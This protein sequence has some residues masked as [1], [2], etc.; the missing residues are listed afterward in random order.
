M[1]LP[2]EDSEKIL[3]TPQQ[4]LQIVRFNKLH[5]VVPFLYSSFFIQFIFTLNTDKTNC[6]A[7]IIF[8]KAA[9]A[10]LCES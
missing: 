2:L 8:Q 7:L 4:K 6:F 9:T 3:N 5:C 10:S 1:F